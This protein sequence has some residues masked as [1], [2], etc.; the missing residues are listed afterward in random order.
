MTRLP[1]H[2][3]NALR[4]AKSGGAAL[5]GPTGPEGPEGPPGPQGEP[6]VGGAS[7]LLRILTADEAKS[8]VNTIQ[9]WFSTGA[10]TLPG[11]TTYLIEGFLHLSN[12]TTTHTTILAFGGTATLTS[13]DYLALIQSQ[14]LNA[15]NTTQTTKVCSAATEQVLNATST[16]ASTFIYVRGVIRTNVGGTLIP[17]FR[18][19]AAPGGSNIAKRNSY[20]KLTS[21]GNNTVTSV[22]TWG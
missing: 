5:P 6:G 12:G 2:V 3:R 14:V 19:S 15:L 18:F 11:G 17:Q 1:S 4:R 10:V 21:I 16:A 9:P 7:D 13:I 22:G 8:N 20:F